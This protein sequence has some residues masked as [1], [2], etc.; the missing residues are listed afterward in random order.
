MIKK[1]ILAIAPHA[2]DVEIAMGGTIARYV[3]EGHNVTIV[4]A[5][6]PQED[7]KGKVDK[8]MTD[9]RLNE[10]KN[11]AAVLGANLDVMNL[12]PY[13]FDY[14]R[15]FIK[16]FDEKINFYKP[17]TIFSCWEHDTHQDHKNLAQILFSVTRKNNI[18]FN[19][20]EVMLPG[21]INTYA[22]NPQ[23]FVNISKY[24]EKKTESIKCYKSVFE[25][26]KNNYSKYFESI[27]GRAKFRG[28][29]IG[30]DYAEAFVVAKKIEI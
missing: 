28:E 21:G 10:Q 7:A 12:D 18:S 26:K 25:N 30:V 4:T 3:D 6:I 1:N 9:N 24:I 27:V 14:S 2:D 19:M 17:D 5:I 15:K 29:V 20:Y 13:E 11:A 23:Y 16:I 8:F 22:F